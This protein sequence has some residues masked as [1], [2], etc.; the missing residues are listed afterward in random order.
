MVDHLHHQNIC[1]PENLGAT[2]ALAKKGYIKVPGINDQN[3]R[4]QNSL[5]FDFWDVF[6]EEGA[7]F[8]PI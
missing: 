1:K 8:V 5:P 7:A 4:P 3:A 6:G 2:E